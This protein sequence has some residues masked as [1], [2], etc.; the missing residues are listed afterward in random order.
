MTSGSV[1]TVGAVKTVVVDGLA[2]DAHLDGEAQITDA[3]VQALFVIGAGVAERAEQP[4]IG[5][6]ERPGV[7]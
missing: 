1:K 5:S 3:G 2:L 7:E 6:P 4:Q